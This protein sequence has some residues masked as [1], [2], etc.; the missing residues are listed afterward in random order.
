MCSRWRKEPRTF[1]HHD[2]SG[3]R[4]HEEVMIGAGFSKLK[5]VETGPEKQVGT[6]SGTQYV[7]LRGDFEVSRPVDPRSSMAGLD[8]PAFTAGK[9]RNVSAAFFA[10]LNAKLRKLNESKGSAL[11]FPFPLEPAFQSDST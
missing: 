3:V 5:L 9:S 8:H 2:Y 11:A 4:L 1:E 7:W 6:K 10:S